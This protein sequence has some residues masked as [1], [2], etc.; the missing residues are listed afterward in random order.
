MKI[1]ENY[2]CFVDITYKFITL[3]LNQVCPHDNAILHINDLN[4]LN[5]CYKHYG[6]VKQQKWLIISTL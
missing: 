3:F 6:H 4:D 1:L 2:E 5:A